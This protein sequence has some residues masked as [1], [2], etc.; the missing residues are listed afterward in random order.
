MTNRSFAGHLDSC[1]TEPVYAIDRCGLAPFLE[2]FRVVGKPLP[3][4]SGNL[5][6]EEPDAFA[7]E[8][9]PAGRYIVCSR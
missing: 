8:V 9:A 4:P 3:K 5:R 6:S 1:A 7:A 2:M